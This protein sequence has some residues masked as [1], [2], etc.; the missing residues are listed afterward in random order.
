MKLYHTAAGS[1]RAAVIFVYSRSLRALDHV[2]MFVMHKYSRADFPPFLS[3]FS[4]C[5]QRSCCSL[6]DCANKAGVLLRGHYR[7][8]SYFITHALN[9]HSSRHPTHAAVYFCYHSTPFPLTLLFSI[10]SLCISGPC[11]IMP[12]LVLALQSCD[13]RVQPSRFD[14]LQHSTCHH[15]EPARALFMSQQPD[16]SDHLFFS[17]SI[18]SCLFLLFSFIFLSFS[19]FFTSFDLSFF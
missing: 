14:N 12:S 16:D 9:R 17:F 18:L 7:R 1:L 4:L 6:L 13:R 5:S 3:S 10:I 15:A 2:N 8:N 11:I 19:L